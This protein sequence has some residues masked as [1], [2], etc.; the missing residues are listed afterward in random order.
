MFLIDENQRGTEI[1]NDAVKTGILTFP[2][3]S[4]FLLVASSFNLN[5]LSA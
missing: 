1:N 3:T 2:K 5:Y 4:P